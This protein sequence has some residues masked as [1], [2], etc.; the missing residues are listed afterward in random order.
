MLQL[1]G[2]FTLAFLEAAFLPVSPALLFIPLA[3][4]N[5][6]FSLLY[7]AVGFSGAMLGSLLGYFI[8]YRLG[9]LLLRKLAKKHSYMVYL[10]SKIKRYG[11]WPLAVS[12]IIPLPY[13]I[14]TLGYGALRAPLGR[15][16]FA[17]ALSR[18]VHYGI[19]VALVM[20]FGAKIL[21]VLQHYHLTLPWILTALLVLGL[22]NQFRRRYQRD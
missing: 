3:L 11:V 10:E 2:L 7:G 1:A 19:Q 21:G 5:P 4:A 22:G 9:H 20:G 8:G 13:E 6:K 15:F 12:G 18:L 17:A 16:I 14:F